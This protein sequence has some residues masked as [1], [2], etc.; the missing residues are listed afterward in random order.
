VWASER[1]DEYGG[2]KMHR[3]SL[4]SRPRRGRHSSGLSDRPALRAGRVTPV[5]LAIH[6]ISIRR[7]APRYTAL[8][9]PWA[10]GRA[11]KLPNCSPLRHLSIRRLRLVRRRIGSADEPTSAP[12]GSGGRRLLTEDAGLDELEI[13]PALALRKERD[14]TANQHRVD[15]GP[16]LVDQAQGGRLGGKR[17]AADRDVALLTDQVER[18]GYPASV[19]DQS[20]F[21]IVRDG[22]LVAWVRAVPR[23]IGD[24]TPLEWQLSGYA[25]PGSGLG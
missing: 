12:R 10:P 23:G 11:C 4:P 19:F 6:D 13:H 14:A 16:V 21:W 15:H 22:S 9:R 1:D 8:M 25:C 2:H 24:G 18:A 17:R 7:R 20:F 3:C 5:A